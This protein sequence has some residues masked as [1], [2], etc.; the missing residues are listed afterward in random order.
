MRL[1][2][3]FDNT[4]VCYDGLFH[5]ICVERGLIPANLPTS[6]SEVRDHLRRIGREDDWTEMQGYVYGARM[7]EADP[8]PGVLEFLRQCVRCARPVCIISH[9]TR[10]PFRGPQYDLHAA[11][12]GW[13][14]HHGVFD[15]DRIGLARS[16]VFLE[17]TGDAKL[18]RIGRQR[19]THFIDDLPEFLSSPAFPAETHR[20]LFDPNLRHETESAFTRSASW[21][22]IARFLENELTMPAIRTTEFERFLPFLTRHGIHV[23]VEL[24]P[25]LEGGNNR[26]FRVHH[27]EGECVLKTYFRS[28]DDPRDR[29]GAERAFLELLWRRGLRRTPQPLGWSDENGWGLLS[30]VPGRKLRSEEVD[31]NRVDEAVDFVLEINERRGDSAAEALLPASEA[32]F[33]LGEHL[34][35]VNRRVARLMGIAPE[36]DVDKEAVEFVREEL[37]P[38]WK[39]IRKQIDD[40]SGAG[41]DRELPGE[42]LCLSPS[43]FGFHNALLASDGHLRFIDFEYAGWDDPAKLVCDFF[44]QPE[45]PIDI[46]HWDSVIQPLAKLFGT[47]AELP[48]RATKLLPA[49][50][51]KWCCIILNEFIR[52][53]SARR[54]F[55]AGGEPVDRKRCQLSKARQELAKAFDLLGRIA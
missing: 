42:L 2:I 33:S 32:C 18:E 44:C 51:I 46:R 38:L 54:R 7:A 10:Y 20:I 12:I 48:A 39:R 36:T 55:A 40:G 41:V 43:D 11:A 8:Y 23:G 4:I 13:L 53:D 49:Y 1:G 47:A 35:T 31:G 27:A 45:L 3:D 15:P 50:Q 26:V 14:E 30:L 21:A 19:C 24:T 6:K 34:A 29:L 28:P 16:Q 37:A 17:L 9:K 52:A 22:E 25:L 5:R